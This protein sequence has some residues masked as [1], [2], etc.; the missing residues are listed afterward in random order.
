MSAQTALRRYGEAYADGNKNIHNVITHWGVARRGRCGRYGRCTPSRFL[1]N[2]LMISTRVE[3]YE[4]AQNNT[5]A[6]SRYERS[7]L[8]VIAQLPVPFATYKRT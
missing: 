5:C 6:L 7:G 8:T 1:S 4:Q 3:N 2:F